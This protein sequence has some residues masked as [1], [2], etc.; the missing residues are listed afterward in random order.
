MGDGRSGIALRED[1]YCQPFEVPPPS[2]TAAAPPTPTST[3]S[4]EAYPGAAPTPTPAL[5]P[6]TP[7]P[8][9]VFLTFKLYTPG[10]QYLQVRVDEGGLVSVVGREIRR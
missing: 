9:P 3:P 2:P 1:V 8:S 5:P 6:P 4:P 10:V 7:T